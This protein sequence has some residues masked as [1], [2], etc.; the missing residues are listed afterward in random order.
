MHE[1]LSILG[2]DK[3]RSRPFRQRL[4]IGEEE[5]AAVLDV[6]ESGKLSSFIGGE[7]RFFN[8]GQKVLAFEKACCKEFH[9]KHAVTVNSWTSGLTAAIG[10]VGVEPGDE[11]IC[12]PFTMSAS[13]TCALFYGGIPVFADIDSETYCLSPESIEACIT[14]RTKAIVVVHLF[15]HAADM[16]R[17]LEITAPRGIRVIEDA[18]QA[19]GVTYRGKKVGSLGDL[20]GFSLNYHKHIHAGE[21]GI[22]VTNS[23]EL[24]H[25]CRLIRN[26]GENANENLSASQLVNAIGGNFRMTELQA[27]IGLKQLGRLRDCLETRQRLA[28]YLSSCLKEIPGLKAQPRQNS[29]AHYLFPI[30]YD[31]E[32]IGISREMFVK[33]VNAELPIPN[34]VETTPLTA[35]YV[36][37]LYLNAVYQKQIAI[38]KNGFPFSFNP[39][40][41]YNYDMGIC[42]KTE[43]AYFQDLLITTLVREPLTEEDLKDFVRAI[44]K[45]VEQADKLREV[46]GEKATREG[47]ILTPVDVAAGIDSSL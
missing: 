20:G 23:D 24:A 15:G 34:G 43:S 32:V 27:A 18:A 38:G 4:T 31:A 17:I 26:H 5:K 16:D 25:R 41:K 29:H 30:R 7:G 42:P 40:V 47:S 8:G 37:P 11:V 21:G 44:T 28:N 35:G 33:A 6:L 9:A 14:S 45:V 36:K 46:F 1:K 10:A 19:P 39:S 2:G 12:S 22:I 3:V 13:A